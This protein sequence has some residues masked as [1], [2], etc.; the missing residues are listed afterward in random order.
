MEQRDEQKLI[1]QSVIAEHV[2]TYFRSEITDS[3]VK[4]NCIVGE[5]SRVRK[6]VLEENVRIDR[7]NLIL[8]CHLGKCTYT[9]PFDML[10]NSDIGSFCSI[11][12]GVTIGPPE[13]D[14]HRL[15]THPFMHND[16]YGILPKELLL[17]VTKFEKPCSIGHDVW[18]G[19]NATIL[20]GGHIGHGAV[21]GANALVNRDVPPYAIV[22][23]VP[24][25]ILKYRFP[26]D[27]IQKLLSIEWWHWD[28][29]R[30]Q[31]NAHLFT[32]E[33]TLE[34]LKNIK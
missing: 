20:R 4:R 5:N 22:G 12:Y 14:F 27:V 31:K 15:S 32:K 11:S 21:I 9:G 8:N 26:Q 23:G 29:E 2:R 25:K 7:N 13:H 30:I 1:S 3:E 28:E 10:F 18:I 17:P 34:D 33:L 6:S 19:C 16:S 24:A